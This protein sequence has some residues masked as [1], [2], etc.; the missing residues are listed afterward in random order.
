LRRALA[1]REQVA[2]AEPDS[3]VWQ[4]EL[5][6]GAH[7]LGD[8]YL[9]T[10]R[11]AEA[12]AHYARAV[13]LRTR[14]VG[15]DPENADYL[16]A[17]A[18]DFVN[19]GNLYQGN[20]RDKA[21]RA[22]AQAEGLLLPLVRAYPDRDEHALTLAGAYNNWGN[23][24]RA[25]GQLQAALERESRAVDLADAVLRLEP[26]H[27]T[28]RLRSFSA[29]GA[30]AQVYEQLGRFADAVRDWDRVVELSEAP[31][32]WMYRIFRALALARAGEYA[33]ATAEADALVEDTAVTADGLYDLACTYA[34]SV[35]PARS[36][37]RLPPAERG[38]AA[39]H[40]AAQA[41]ALLTKLHARG[42]FHAA[43][44]RDLLK[45][46]PDLA[47]LRSRVD[48]QKLLSGTES[49]AQR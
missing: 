32:A 12:E 17:L 13:A 24:L 2:E 25:Q 22:L 35:G 42:Y 49:N 1:L 6:K 37:A 16:S 43:E 4:N 23:L 15:A 31:K 18:G 7:N 44:H 20:D 45:T 34:L 47:S 3:P 29:H 46:D 28:A 11:P 41:M 9:Q 39:D 48:F 36:D 26:R 14:L 30:R 5:A 40:Y 21:G 10:G 38:R 8:V 33:R 19:L 27:G